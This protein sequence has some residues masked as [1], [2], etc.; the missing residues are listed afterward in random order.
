MPKPLQSLPPKVETASNVTTATAAQSTQQTQQARDILERAL[1][2]L[3]LNAPVLIMNAGSLCTLLAF[4]RTDVL[5][6]RSL[7]VTG[8]VCFIV[9]NLFQAPIKW[10]M[11]GWTSLFASVNTYFIIQI[12]NERHSHVEMTPQQ[13]ACFQKYFALYG[14]TPKQFEVIANKAEQIAV[15]K[16]SPVIKQGQKIEHVYLVVEGSTRASI[17]GRYLTAASATPL[18]D[19]H[20][21]NNNNNNKG[22]S[23]TSGAWVGEMAFLEACW[24]KEMQ[25]QQEKKKTK[26]NKNN[27]PPPPLAAAHAMYTVMAR[28]D[29]IVWRWT[30]ND[31]EQLMRRSGDM[32]DALTR[33]MTSAIVGK[34][35]NFTVSR[36]SAR[37]TWQTW[38]DN[39]KAQ[40]SATIANYQSGND[41]HDEDDVEEE[42]GDN[43]DNNQEASKDNTVGR[44]SPA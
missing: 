23:G 28:E 32:R 25:Q 33:A 9:Y 38:L 18:Q 29:C 21:S 35:I 34:V 12:V 3:K 14:I 41:N 31:M 13:E 6:L 40:R 2:F 44:E 42:V 4:T 37:P 27:S 16:N 43:N 20:D 11:I 7:S 26:Q 10:L 5:E 15:P 22:N 17:L 24:E 1:E 36:S 8:S 39:W 30:H 19:Q